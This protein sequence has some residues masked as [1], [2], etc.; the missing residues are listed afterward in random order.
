MCR[1]FGKID[2]EG[3]MSLRNSLWFPLL[4]VTVLL[5]KIVD[6]SSLTSFLMVL[7]LSLQL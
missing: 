3:M 7:L 1:I 5:L 2:G 6:E 4:T